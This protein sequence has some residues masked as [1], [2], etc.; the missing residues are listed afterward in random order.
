[1]C[2][3]WITEQTAIVSLVF[4]RLS[5]I[6][7]SVSWLRH[8]CLSV[9]PSVRMSVLQS[10]WNNSAPVGRIFMK[11][12]ICVFFENLA[13][14]FKFHLNWT[15]IRNTVHEDRYDDMIWYDMIWYDMIW[16]YDDTMVWWYD[17]MMIACWVLLRMRTASDRSG[18]ETRNVYCILYI[19]YCILYIV[20]S[21]IFF[22]ENRAVYKLMWRNIAML[23]RPQMATWR[24]CIACSMPKATNPHTGCI[25]LIVFHYNNGCMNAHQCY[26]ALP[27]LLKPRWS[28]YCAV[29]AGS[30]KGLPLLI[31]VAYQ[32]FIHT[33]THMHTHSYTHTRTHTCT[34]THTHTHAH[35]HKLTLTHTHSHTHTHTHSHSH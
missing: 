6:A 28:V 8:V 23:D 32:P 21:V 15:R 14:K 7:K 30:L 13:R 11:F 16:W 10:A 20:Y 22:T 12:D 26:R 4:K 5:K 35:S 27:V 33:H 9:R 19:V 2:F 31:G 34:L 17:Y 29:R 18:R 24:M 1:M 25:I 3:V